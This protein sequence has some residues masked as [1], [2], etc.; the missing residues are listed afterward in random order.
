MAGVRMISRSLRYCFHK[1]AAGRERG[2]CVQRLRHR[3]SRRQSPL[4]R[5]DTQAFT[6]ID[7]TEWLH[8][9]HTHS[10]SRYQNSEQK[11]FGHLRCVDISELPGLN[12][13]PWPEQESSCHLTTLCVSLFPTLVV[14]MVYL[15]RTSVLYSLPTFTTLRMT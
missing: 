2:N 10:S 4:S 8:S 1:A 15:V 5:Q 6:E 11:I 7:D 12:T 13:H 14:F 9:N 3:C